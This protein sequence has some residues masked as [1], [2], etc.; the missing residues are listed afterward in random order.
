MMETGFEFFF[1]GYVS[2]IGGTFFVQE[3]FFSPWNFAKVI[4]VFSFF[5]FGIG[6]TVR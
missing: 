3:N 5:L 1:F 2:E 4:L 6:D